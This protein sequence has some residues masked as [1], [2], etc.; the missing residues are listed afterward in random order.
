MKR[1]ATKSLLAIARSGIIPT[2]LKKR[3][4]SIRGGFEL[5]GEKWKAEDPFRGEPEEWRG[6]SRCPYVLG[7]LKEFWHLHWPYIAACRELDVDYKLLD[8]T[9][10]DWL[11]VV[12]N[13][14][15]D[16]Y[17]A[18]PSVQCGAWKQMYDERLRILAA[19]A[20]RPMVPDFEALWMW[21]SK[22]RMHY[23]LKVNGIAH[24]KTW[25]F[26]DQREALDFARNCDLPIVYKSD[27]GSGASGVLI[28]H[29]RRGLAGHIK[30]C[31]RK[32]FSTYRRPKQDIEYG[33][34]LFQE[35][36][37]SLR[38]W[39]TVRVG[40]SFFAYE[41]A[42][43]AGFHS[44]S[45]EFR[46]GRPPHDVLDLCREVTDVGGFSSMNIDV[47]VTD[48]GRLLVNELQA[49]C[50]QAGSRELCRIDGQ[51][52]RMVY[53][54]TQQTWSFDPGTFCTNYLCNLRVRQ[55][56]DVLSRNTPPRNALQAEKVSARPA[57]REES[58]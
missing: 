16:G 50:G 34:V 21:E 23:W 47:F 58:P 49:I 19:Q 30:R 22:R 46:Y 29:S 31:F 13:A 35:F 44:G 9:R 33:S 14:D 37:P 32:G 11:E 45:G 6:S 3:L 51:T 53:D 8:V 20:A 52:G 17:L 54:A 1:L 7:I 5:R 38:E 25:V 43:K 27:M 4:F 24:P 55:L 36:L 57:S 10:S 42:R 12:E 40:D 48:D 39:R 56:L 41:K 26:Y 18:R 28:F 2:G 15:C